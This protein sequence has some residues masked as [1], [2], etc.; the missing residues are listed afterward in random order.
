MLRT[1]SSIMYFDK[2]KF[3]DSMHLYATKNSVAFHNKSMLKKLNMPVAVCSAEKH[4][5]QTLATSEEE[6]LDTKVLL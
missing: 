5:D 2:K 6:Q 3:E 4:R 1:D